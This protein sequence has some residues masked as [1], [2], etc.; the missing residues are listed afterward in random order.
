MGTLIAPFAW[1][2]IPS[3]SDNQFLGIPVMAVSS[4]DQPKTSEPAHLKPHKIPLRLV[5]IVPFVLEILVAVGLTGW[6]SLRNGQ[7]AVNDLAT[8]LEY[9]VASRI[10]QHLEDYLS[11]PEQINQTNAEAIRLGLLDIE[12]PTQLSRTFWQQIQIEWDL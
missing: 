12:D 6:F 7:R 11:V 2:L 9:E 10:E 5:L 4:L 1:L 8:Q 3:L